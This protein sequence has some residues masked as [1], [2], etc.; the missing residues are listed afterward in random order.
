M[1]Q[2]GVPV[3]IT[4]LQPGF[5]DTAMLKTRTPLP[6]LVRRLLVCDASTAAKQMLRAIHR[7]QKHAY[8][9]KR[10]GPL[11]LLLKVLPRPG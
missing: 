10:Y 4:E 1:Q 11:A 9:T 3:T 7:K 5:V 2:A 8:I 6:P